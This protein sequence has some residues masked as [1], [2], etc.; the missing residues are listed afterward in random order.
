MEL[1]RWGKGE[2]RGKRRLRQRM[3]L[4]AGLLVVV[5][6]WLLLLWVM[7]EMMSYL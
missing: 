6:G 7:G 3:L 1:R 2:R 5:A 4:I